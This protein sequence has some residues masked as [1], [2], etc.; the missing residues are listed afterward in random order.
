[1][2]KSRFCCCKNCIKN[3][4]LQIFDCVFD[5]IKNED[6][7]KAKGEEKGNAKGGKG[8][9]TKNHACCLLFGNDNSKHIQ[10]I[11]PSRM[12]HSLNGARKHVPIFAGLFVGF[13]LH[14][15]LQSTIQTKS[16]SVHTV[17]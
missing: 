13:N 3:T 8:K 10:K 4:N 9:E 1:M 14:F 17:N 2:A 12:R 6:E 16:L 15:F 5:S 7:G 11:K